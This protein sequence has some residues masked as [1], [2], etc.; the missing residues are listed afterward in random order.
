MMLIKCLWMKIQMGF[1]K[2]MKKL[3]QNYGLQN[4]FY[5]LMFVLHV[6]AKSENF[7]LIN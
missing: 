3:I 6:R 1:E 4:T 2:G 7:L 5:G